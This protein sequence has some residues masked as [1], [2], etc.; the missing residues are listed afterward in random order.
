M[1][2]AVMPPTV[3]I[4]RSGPSRWRARRLVSLA[5]A[6]ATLLAGVT[7]AAA[8]PASADSV[9]NPSSNS[10]VYTLQN[11]ATGDIA[12]D[13]NASTDAG[14]AIGQWPSNGATNQQW[15]IV[16]STGSDAGYY[17]IQ[18]NEDGMCLD[19]SG[20][21]TADGAPVIQWPCNGQDNQEWQINYTGSWNGAAPIGWIVNKNSGLDLNV[22]RSADGTGLVQGSSTWYTT[23]TNGSEMWSNQWSVIRSTGGIPFV[24]SATNPSDNGADASQSNLVLEVP[25]SSTGW[26]TPVDLQGANGG[27]NQQWYL[28]AAGTLKFSGDGGSATEYRIINANG[29]TGPNPVCLEAEGS[30][31]QDGAVVDEYGCDPNSINQPNQLWII[32]SPVTGW[33]SG[34]SSFGSSAQAEVWNVATFKNY[35]NTGDGGDFPD[36]PVIAVT[37]TRVP[38][39]GSNMTL[40][41]S[42]EMD[43]SVYPST[44]IDWY[45]NQIVP[46][47]GSSNGSSNAPTCT[48]FECLIGG[49]G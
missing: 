2:G 15:T 16:S 34:A 4:D 32:N 46:S 25:S 49:S 41:T 18:N 10:T 35:D 45:L 5:A 26:G 48:M 1:K 47:S 7:L 40:Q 12:D 11:Q 42:N 27:T 31:P 14:N 13:L 38:A 43:S 23:A 30:N 8:G 22:T 24:M 21:S 17:T 19:V 37:S 3:S 28:Q 20:Q 36:S 29:A 39:P 33:L 6:G 44:N 9:I